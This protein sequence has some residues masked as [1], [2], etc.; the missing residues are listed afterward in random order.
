MT[1]H[2]LLCAAVLLGACGGDARETQPGAADSAARAETAAPPQS[3]GPRAC[4]LL[5]VE[6]IEHATSLDLDGG[7]T[8]SDYMGVSQCQWQRAGGGADGGVMVSLH[9]HG[10]ILNYQKVP[11]SEM[12]GGLGDG[13]VWNPQ[14]NQLAVKRG[15]AV[16]SISFMFSPAEQAWATSLARSAIAK[17][18]Q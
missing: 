12:I 5:T 15:E 1:R 4:D 18:Q 6:E 10:E 14:T 11:G 17:L 9:E 8:V 2:A 7:V 3:S 13:A 16:V